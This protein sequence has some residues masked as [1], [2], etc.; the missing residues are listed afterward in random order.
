[1]F[2]LWS[3]RKFSGLR[4]FA[5]WDL[6][7]P[8]RSTRPALGVS[9][10][11]FHCFFSCLSDQSFDLLLPP[12]FGWCWS[13][14]AVSPFLHFKLLFSIYIRWCH[15][16][17][18]AFSL[19][20]P[21]VVSVLLWGHYWLFPILFFHF[22]LGL[23]PLT[24]SSLGGLC[25]CV[26]S[27]LSISVPVSSVTR[28]LMLCQ[29]WHFSGRYAS[30]NWLDWLLRKRYWSR[31]SPCL[32]SLKHPLLNHLND[33]TFTQP[34]KQTWS[35]SPFAVVIISCAVFL[36]VVISI[37]GSVVVSSV[38]EPSCTPAFAG[39]RNMCPRVRTFI[40][41]CTNTHAMSNLL[42]VWT[43]VLK[44]SLHKCLPYAH[45]DILYSLQLK[46]TSDTL[47]D[48]F[49]LATVHQWIFW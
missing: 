19:L 37:P 25:T 22:T 34:Q 36:L 8:W 7:S 2:L 16:S 41:L 27:S 32:C 9:E 43:S 24:F 17:F 23:C 38:I 13:C 5:S 45:A 14:L 42:S 10:A 47:H 46:P 49:P 12:G 26:G 3:F 35:E 28:V 11:F 1:M 20:C 48:A 30:I 6:M 40:I 21:L 33:V 44:F 15:P 31:R 29:L 39:S 4:K 18:P